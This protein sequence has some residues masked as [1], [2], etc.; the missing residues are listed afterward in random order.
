MERV[1]WSRALKYAALLARIEVEM[2]AECKEHGFHRTEECPVCGD[3]GRFLMNEE[4]LDRVG[5]MM[6][7]ILRHFP[8]RFDLAM[9][10]NGWVDLNDMVGA[11]RNARRNLHWL[12]PHHIRAIAETDEKGRYQVEGGQV[13]ATYGHSVDVIM[14]DLPVSQTETLFYPVSE[15]ELDIVLEAGLHP[16]DRRKLHLSGSFETAYSAGSV[17]MDAPIVLQVDAAAAVASGAAIRRA[18]KAVYVAE[19]ID[20]TFLSVAP[21]PTGFDPEQATADLPPR[22]VE[23]GARPA[24]D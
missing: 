16:T 7:G 3:R 18:G 23:R 11:M 24:A 21:I 4:E 2:L 13:R 9:D 1:A 15:E 6:A 10:S 12:R 22:P 14:D 8:E 17:H 20:S 19:D 5:R